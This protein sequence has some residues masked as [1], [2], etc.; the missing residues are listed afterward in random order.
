MKTKTALAILLLATGCGGQAED[1]GETSSPLGDK[2]STQQPDDGDG[3]WDVELPEEQVDGDGRTGDATSKPDTVAHDGQDAP[4]VGGVTNPAADDSDSFID[5]DQ[6]ASDGVCGPNT[7]CGADP[8]CSEGGDGFVACAEYIEEADGV[9][10]RDPFDPCLFQDPDCKNPAA[11]DTDSLIDCSHVPE[12][13]GVCEGGNLCG[14]DPDCAEPTDGKGDTPVHCFAPSLPNGECD[15]S[16]PCGDPDCESEPADGSG[17]DDAV[18]CFA[19]PTSDGVCDPSDP[20]GDL[21]CEPQS[22]TGDT[23]GGGFV[24]CAEYIEEPDGVCSRNETDPCAFQDPDCS[25][26]KPDEG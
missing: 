15:P 23:A 26:V 21:D 4:I 10:N 7:V 5:C 2:P 6:I 16:D 8:D 20:C 14:N 12:A 3:N 25:E 22:G 19:P 13:D 9:C 17:S 18:N 1:H 24:A 11:D